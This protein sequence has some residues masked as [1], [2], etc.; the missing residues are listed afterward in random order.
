[1]RVCVCLNVC[2]EMIFVPEERPHISV[3]LVVEDL[4]GKITVSSGVSTPPLGSSSIFL[5]LYFFSSLF[6]QLILE[7]FLQALDSPLY[8]RIFV[9]LQEAVYNLKDICLDPRP[10]SLT[11]SSRLLSITNSCAILAISQ[12][13]LLLSDV[14]LEYLVLEGL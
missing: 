1:M 14:F 12:V 10:L 4:S 8:L 2:D 13:F 5:C 7:Y 6:S 9:T 11:S 3:R